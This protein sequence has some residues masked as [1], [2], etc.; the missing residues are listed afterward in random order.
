MFFYTD[1]RRKKTGTYDETI[2]TF[3][4]LNM[5]YLYLV[6]CN[7]I[8]FSCHKNYTLYFTGNT[9]IQGQMAL[10][11]SQK[12]N[13]EQVC[14]SSVHICVATLKTRIY[15]V[16]IYII[17]LYYLHSIFITGDNHQF[18]L[19]FLTLINIIV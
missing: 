19:R 17:I 16:S 3:D 15:D 6:M 18:V 11:Y 1:D 9:A 5:T 7:S 4:R 10:I 13:S 2:K 12:Y 8:L 14:E